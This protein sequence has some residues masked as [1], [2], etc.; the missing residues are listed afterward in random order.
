[1]KYPLLLASLFLFASCSS[2]PKGGSTTASAASHAAA[3]KSEY[4][5]NVSMVSTVAP[6]SGADASNFTWYDSEGRLVSLSDLKGKTVLINFW[7]TWCGPCKAELPDIESLSKAYASKGLVV[8]G[9]S[10]DRGDGML[11]H[12]SDF[13][14]KHGLTYQ[15]V[16]DNDDIANA[17]GS[18]NAI[19]TSFIVSKNGQIVDKWIGERDKAFFES[20]ISKFL[21]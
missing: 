9:V 20:T 2:K 11:K 5:Q 13:A 1:M 17:F 4:M 14:A 18:I 7:A 15:I 21:D 16:I 19:P 10:E 12:V 3:L 8:V 6:S